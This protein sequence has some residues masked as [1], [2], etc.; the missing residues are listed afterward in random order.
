MRKETN[1]MKKLMLCALAVTML[2]AL[3]AGATAQGTKTKLVVAGWPA[4]DVAMKAII[5]EFNKKFP[6]VEVVLNFMATADHHQQLQTAVAAG[7]GAPD[8]AMIEQGWIGK[9]R[10]SSGFEN[11][12]DAPYSAGAM[13]KDFVDYKWQIAASVDGKKLIGLVWDIGP[14]TLFYN[15]TVFK[16]AGLPTEPAD[17]DRLLATWD[18]VLKAAKAVYIPNKRWLIN[19]AADFYIWNYMNRDYYNDKLELQLDKP[20]ATDALKAALTMRKNGWDAN[21]GLWTNETYSGLGSGQYA[22]VVAG[23]WY[24][25]FLK[26]WIAPKA[27]GQWGVAHIPGKIPSSNWG[28]SYMAIP[29]QSQNKKLAWE[30]I[31]FAVATK[32]GQNTQFKTVDYFP[33]YIPA[34]DDPMYKEGDPY[35]AGQKTKALWVEIAKGTKPTFSTLMDGT[36]ENTIGNVVNSGLNEGKSPEEIIAAAKKQ[37]AIDTRDDYDRNVDILKKAGKLK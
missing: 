20:A 9:F 2:F 7:S 34:W 15:R 4:G 24:G 32:Y 25:G 18:G 8:V 13:K 26:S 17:V 37:I 11:L 3:A 1:V 33:G 6:D 5:P 35:F 19:S 36:V 16:D 31:K 10:D 29:S 12:L 28:G 14:A 21:V 27:S 30:F 23:C 22:M